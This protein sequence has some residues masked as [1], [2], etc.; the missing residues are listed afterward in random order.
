MPNYNV[1]ML[2][3]SHIKVS[4]D[5]SDMKTFKF[6]GAFDIANECQVKDIDILTTIYTSFI[7]DANEQ[8]RFFQQLTVRNRNQLIY[9]YW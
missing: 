6:Q 5:S 3:S 2:Y 9:A 8:L 7:P 1:S 4:M